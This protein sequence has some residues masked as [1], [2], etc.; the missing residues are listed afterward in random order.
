MKS[1]Y[2]VM[3]CEKSDFSWGFLTEDVLAIN[4]QTSQIFVFSKVLFP[5]FPIAVF[6]L[7][8]L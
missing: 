6:K 2:E 7:L 3:K 4:N 8:F 5:G 1:W